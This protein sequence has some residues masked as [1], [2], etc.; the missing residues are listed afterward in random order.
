M[1][2][3]KAKNNLDLQTEIDKMNNLGVIHEIRNISDLDEAP[4]AYKNIE[5]VI[6]LELDLIKPI[7]E[8]TP[9]VSIKG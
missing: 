8:L 7:V 4:G 6:D 9:I 3:T 2:R 1:S 5:R